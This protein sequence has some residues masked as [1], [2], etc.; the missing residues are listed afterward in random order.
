MTVEVALVLSVVSVVFSIYFGY[1]NSKHTDT[2]ELEQ[3]VKENTTINLKL[4][5]IAASIDDVKIDLK[6]I[7]TEMKQHNDRIIKVEESVKSAHKRIDEILKKIEE[8][9]KE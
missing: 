1:K 3:R 8:T 6:A 2:K 7:K 4:D 5:G 9:D